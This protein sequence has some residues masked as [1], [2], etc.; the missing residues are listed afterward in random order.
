MIQ[1]G[2]GSGPCSAPSQVDQRSPVSGVPVS[3]VSKTGGACRDALQEL[4]FV[5]VEATLARP[6]TADRLEVVLS[7]WRV[8]LVGV[9]EGSG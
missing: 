2:H 5:V 1:S 9:E 7:H 8:S 3:V 4:W 6:A